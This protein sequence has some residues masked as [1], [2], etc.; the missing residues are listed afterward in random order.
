MNFIRFCCLFILSFHLSLSLFLPTFQSTYHPFC[1]CTSLSLSLSFY[2]PSNLLIFPFFL[3]TSLSVS[4]FLPTFQSTYYPFL[5]VY[6]S[7]FT[8]L[9]I[10]LSSLSVCVLL[11]LY[12]YICL[13]TSLFTSLF[14]LIFPRNPSSIFLPHLFDFHSVLFSF[15]LF[16]FRKLLKFIFK[17][18]VSR[19][20]LWSKE[21]KYYEADQRDG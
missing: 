20:Y 19:S 6:L 9:P 14:P 3:C 18:F 4:L 12:R 8:Y 5:S 21:T 15:S 1:L 13:P 11:F 10:C 17:L 7:L 16:L 2:L